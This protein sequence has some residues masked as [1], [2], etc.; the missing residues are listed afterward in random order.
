MW[1]RQTSGGGKLCIWRVC[2]CFRK[3][4]Y[5]GK[6]CATHWVICD[7]CIHWWVKWNVSDTVVGDLGCICTPVCVQ[8]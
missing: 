1:T 3:C 5:R 2:E 4:L 8:W 7:L 6:L